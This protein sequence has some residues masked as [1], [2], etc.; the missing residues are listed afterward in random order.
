MCVNIPAVLQMPVPGCCLAVA[1][2]IG[3][4]NA[5]PGY[6]PYD[7]S[8]QGCVQGQWLW[9]EAVEMTWHAAAVYL[10]H[11]GANAA[12]EAQR[13]KAPRP[14]LGACRTPSTRSAMR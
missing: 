12:H 5:F 9:N 7:R 13:P 3:T 11:C 10:P 6:D 4:G 8:S 2:Y 14:R 1:P